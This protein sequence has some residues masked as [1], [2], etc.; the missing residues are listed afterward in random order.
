VFHPALILNFTPDSF[1]DGSDYLEKGKALLEARTHDYLKSGGTFFDIGA[2]STAPQNVSISY[3]EECQRLKT[4]FLPWLQNLQHNFPALLPHIT[5]SF[6]TYKHETLY[7][8]EQDIFSQISFPGRKVWNDVSGLLDADTLR[9]MTDHQE[10][11]YIACHSLVEKREEAGRHKDFIQKDL[12]I[13]QDI[14]ERFQQFVSLWTLSAKLDSSRLILDPCFGFAKSFE[15]NQKLLKCLPALMKKFS[16]EQSWLIGISRKSFLRE[17]VKNLKE[18]HSLGLW[19]SLESKEYPQNLECLHALW[20][21]FFYGQLKEHK[22]PLYWRLHDASVFWQ[23][24][25]VFAAH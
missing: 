11:S 2:E 7:F 17:E 19:P 22:A 8:L 5:L 12:D 25:K 6:D 4:F 24:Q 16:P 20:M 23:W 3:E 13:M 18:K 14:E 1:S 21:A 10:W 15:Q 9:F